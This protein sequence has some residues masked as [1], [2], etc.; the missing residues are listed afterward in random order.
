MPADQRGPGP[1]S[2]P[3]FLAGL[4]PVPSTLPGHPAPWPAVDIDGVDPDGMRAEVRLDEVREPLL[5]AF[6]AVRCD[7][8]EAFWDGL[9]PD[10][11]LVGS[12]PLRVVV[13]TRGPSTVDPVAVG[14]LAERRGLEV[15]MSDRAWEGYRVS[16]YPFFVL[17]DPSARTVV[18]E[19]VAF[20]LEDVSALVGGGGGR[21]PAG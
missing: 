3:E 14:R 9:G 4:R 5:L 2:D 10:G 13:V 6:L 17:V 21:G 20:G 8:C 18:G 12:S 1:L 15:V 7:G 16:G 19:A 11:P